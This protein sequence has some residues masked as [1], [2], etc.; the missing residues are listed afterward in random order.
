MSIRFP[1]QDIKPISA[2]YEYAILQTLTS[3]CVWLKCE[4]WPIYKIWNIDPWQLQKAI[5][6]FIICTCILI[7]GPITLQRF[8]PNT[9]TSSV[10]DY[11]IPLCSLTQTFLNSCMLATF[12]NHTLQKVRTYDKQHT[13]IDGYSMRLPYWE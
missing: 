3:A 12:E 1:P 11:S 8:A 2:S 7:F 13:Q 4:R 9:S 10:F 5:I 6:C